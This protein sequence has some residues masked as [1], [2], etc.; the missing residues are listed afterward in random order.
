MSNQA[1]VQATVASLGLPG[2]IPARV[3]PAGPQV[4]TSYE[5][6][7]FTLNFQGI[8]YAAVVYVTLYLVAVLV[9]QRF[10]TPY[11]V[12]GLLAA[13]LSFMC[14]RHFNITARWR[15]GPTGAEGNRVIG[16]WFGIVGTLLLVAYMTQWSVYFS[17]LVL[18]MWFLAAP[19]ALLGLNF[20]MHRA[21]VK[22]MPEV[23]G[24]RKAAMVFANDAARRFAQSVKRSNSF[25]LVGLFED[26]ELDRVGGDLDTVPYLGSTASAAQYIRD[27]NISV[28]FIFLSLAESHR[29][30]DLIDAL[31][32]TTASVY[33][34]PDFKMFDRFDTRMISV[35]SVPMF[36][37]VESPFHGIDGLVKQTFDAVL[38]GLA[39]L[40]LALPLAIVALLVKLTSP[41]PVFF[42]QKRYGL[43]G[44]EFWIYKFRSMYEADR[45]TE[46]VQVA[47]GDSRVTPLGRIL[48]STS[49]DELPQLFNVI[50]GEMSLV[51]P[52]PHTVAHNEFYRKA[53]RR[54]MV[55]HKV[56]P[57]LT[58]LAQVEG[59]RGETP[60]LEQMEKRVHF[61]LEYIKAWSP[62]LDLQIIFR[63]IGVI[64]R[65][66]NAY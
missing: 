57:G 15:V 30:A 45:S 24:P 36:E 13:M 27:N 17:R 23:A 14:M 66:Q 64:L 10:E 6:S 28:V 7:T 54:Y 59:Y 58:G 22:V 46:L 19:T 33:Y 34:V 16:A 37:I 29:V 5:L 48:R 12:I 38:A 39:L 49:I 20:A 50:K 3:R 40:L 11:A 51:G 2:L 55:R 41:G 62:L 44:K 9:G 47:R 1:Q 25:D 60:Q 8:L 4:P 32:D 42:K 56:R 18:T 65:R 63:T 61:D 31:G 35:E 52:R 26:R 43:N 21:A 53:V